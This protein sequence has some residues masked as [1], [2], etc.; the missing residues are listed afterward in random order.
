MDSKEIQRQRM[1]EYF[2]NAAKEIILEEGVKNLTARKVGNKAGYSY[3]TIYNYFSD[4]NC[5]SIHCVLDFLEDC[6]KHVMNLRNVEDDLR[7][8]VI[9]CGTEYFKFFVKNP[10]MFQLIFLETLEGLPQND[11]ERPVVP[12]IALLL[13]NLLEECALKGYI[14]NENIDLLAELITS[15]IHGKLLFYVKGRNTENVDNIIMSIRN[16]MRYLLNIER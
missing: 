16:E 6:Y 12:S 9:D 14:K 10:Q 1:R 13:K 15:T 5:L 3:A 7:D 11:E 4:L 2:I 8:Q